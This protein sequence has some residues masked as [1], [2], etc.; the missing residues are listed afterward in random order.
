MK[1]EEIKRDPIRDTLISVLQYL[2]ENT[3][4]LWTSLILIS[5]LIFAVTYFSNKNQK[6]MLTD[7]ENIGIALIDEI[8]TNTENDSLR[9]LEFIN[10]LNNATTKEGY[11]IAFIYILNKSYNENDLITV[12]DL[13]S[14]NKFDSKDD[15]LNTYLYKL[16]ADDHLQDSLV[17]I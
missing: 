14:N 15:M 16:K 6:D 5:I 8:Y 3:Y 17:S 4:M 11:N 7:N 9:K 1:K 12:K 13:L 10:F 2:S